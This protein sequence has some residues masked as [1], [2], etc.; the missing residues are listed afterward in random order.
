VD[1]NGDLLGINSFILSQSGTSSGVGFAI[2]AALVR[3]VVET[4]AGGGHAVVRPWFGA[5]LQSVTPEMARS[6]GLP[7]P[8]GALVADVCPGGPGAR[9][10]VKQGDVVVSAEGNPVVDA[11]GL[12]YAVGTKRPGDTISVG[13]RR[14]G[15]TQTVNV[16]A[17]APP[18]TPA[19]DE[20]T[21]G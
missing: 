11:A 8:S 5:R 20:Q 19:K 1:M 4:A 15:R 6:L 12:N 17:E 21:I 10:G 18:A 14:D 7:T 3:R 9:A 13:I 16:H 2:P